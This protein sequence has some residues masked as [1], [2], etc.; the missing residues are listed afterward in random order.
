MEP[1]DIPPDRV[2]RLNQQPITKRRYVLYWMQHSQRAEWNHALEYAVDQANLMRQPVLVCFG[3]TE[4]YP[5]ANVRHYAFML[6]GLRETRR[7]LEERG[8]GMTVTKGSPEV[9]ALQFARGA[10][11]VVCDRGFLRH[12]KQWRTEVALRSEA[13]VV[14]VE[15]DTTVPVESASDKA[16]VAARTFRPKIRARLPE[17]LRRPLARLPRA[18]SLDIVDRGL[19]LD[20]VPG[21]LAGLQVDRSVPPVSEFR[22]GIT[23]A[24]RRLDSFVCEQLAGY[25]DHRTRPELDHVSHLSPYLHF[26]QISPLEIAARIL[27][28]NDVPEADRDAFIDE[29]IIRRE[30]A[31]NFVHFNV[32]Y[33]RFAGLPAWARAS[34]LEHAGDPRP[35]TYSTDQLDA[36][37]TRDPYW[38]AAMLE[39]KQTGYMHNYMRMYWGKKILEWSADPEKAYYTIVALNNRYLLDGR[40]PSSYANVGW[41][42]GLHDRPW[43]ERPIFGKVRYMSAGGLKRKADMEA[44]IERVRKP[45]DS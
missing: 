29:L 26:G 28:C 10:S 36:A 33:D 16:E 19:E 18:D 38:N 25:A 11:L 17:Y 2:Q 5:E 12:Q 42:F 3:I 14:Q 7:A 39:M 30:L 23:E 4:D 21:L 43:F 31:H 15:T 27:E 32:E 8:I 34:L 13:E 20:D 35:E 37:E 1:T 24:R 22:G 9:V 44:Y 40:D 41:I 6:E 45:A